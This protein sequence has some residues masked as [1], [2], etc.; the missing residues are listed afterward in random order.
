MAGSTED[1]FDAL[2][3]RIAA[4]EARRGRQVLLIQNEGRCD[5]GTTEAEQVLREIE[6]E[7][8]ALRARTATFAS[9]PRHS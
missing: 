6:E 2:E 9:D 8:E 7:L 5:Q 1:R 3:A 4:L